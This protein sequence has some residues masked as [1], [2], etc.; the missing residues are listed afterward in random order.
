MLITGRLKI[1]RGMCSANRFRGAV[2]FSC[3]CLVMT[4]KYK[5]FP[6]TSHPDLLAVYWEE[7]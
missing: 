4:K 3:V 6:T 1:E 7:V 5:A 2:L